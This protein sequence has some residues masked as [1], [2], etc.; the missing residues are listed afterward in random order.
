M[1]RV[2]YS[3]CTVFRLPDPS[4][5][6]LR[7]CYSGGQEVNERRQ[8]AGGAVAG[9]GTLEHLS[10]SYTGFR[11][12]RMVGQ[13]QQHHQYRQADSSEKEDS[14]TKE[15]R[16]LAE[17]DELGSEVFTLKL[18]MQEYE[19][20]F[21]KLYQT[22]DRSKWRG[23]ATLLVSV[24]FFFFFPFCF[25]SQC[26]MCRCRN[27]GRLPVGGLAAPHQYYCCTRRLFVSPH[28]I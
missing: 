14:G 8:V 13:Q 10:I 17:M 27:G 26:T 3:D 22:E 16:R 21:A 20:R 4:L 9:P 2:I 25:T 11:G 28:R 12:F 24:P 5:S 6:T 7:P 23:P 19:D 1:P 15:D 18:A